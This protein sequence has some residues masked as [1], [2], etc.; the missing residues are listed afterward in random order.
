MIEEIITIIVNEL[1]PVGILIVGLYFV[2]SKP[3]KNMAYS[4]NVINHELGKMLKIM[5][6]E[7]WHKSKDH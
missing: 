2:L 4:L 7:K 3:L 6:T 1:G 5:E